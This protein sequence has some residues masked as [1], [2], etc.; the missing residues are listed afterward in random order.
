MSLTA[1]FWNAILINRSSSSSVAA[2]VCDSG[3]AGTI[4]CGQVTLSAE[5]RW[6]NSE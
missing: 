5:T 6:A 2:E 4:D 3:R 1:H